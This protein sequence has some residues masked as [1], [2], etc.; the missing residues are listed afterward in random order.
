M[1]ENSVGEAAVSGILCQ[2]EAEL[3][4]CGAV[5]RPPRSD[6]ASKV[7][8]ANQSC[9]YE[10]ESELK[11]EILDDMIRT[12][13]GRRP[14][15]SKTRFGPL[16]NHLSSR[17]RVRGGAGAPPRSRSL[18]SSRRCFA[19]RL[20]LSCTAVVRSALSTVTSPR[21]VS[22]AVVLEVAGWWSRLGPAPRK[23]VHL[24]LGCG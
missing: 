7:A 4:H 22:A 1:S 17:W 10:C 18:K 14:S 2:R 15:P 12:R 16:I 23:R 21:N 6:P 24:Q 9:R 19:P 11:M 8:S 3:A 5:E 20:F 13:F